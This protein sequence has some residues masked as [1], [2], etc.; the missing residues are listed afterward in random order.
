[1][2][3]AVLAAFQEAGCRPIP[4]PLLE[5]FAPARMYALEWQDLWVEIPGAD[6]LR[7]GTEWLNAIWTSRFR[8]RFENAIGLTTVQPFA[9][10]TPLSPPVPLV[11]LSPK[12]PE[13][14]SHWRFLQALVEDLYRRATRLPFAIT[15]PTRHRVAES[16]RPPTPLFVLHFLVYYGPALQ[17][18][19][20]HILAAPHRELRRRETIVPIHRATEATPHTLLAILH[21]PETWMPTRRIPLARRLGG[22]A[23]THVRHPQTE[24]TTD[25]APNRFVL[26][27]LRQL[28]QA[29]ET[30]LRQPWWP[31]VPQERQKA[32]HTITSLVQQ[33]LQHPVFHHVSDLHFMPSHSQVLLRRPG[34]REMWELW[35][36]FQ[37]ARRPVFEPM[38]QAIEL[39]D[40]ATLYEYWVFFA[41]IEEIGFQLEVTPTVQWQF[42]RDEGLGWHA[43]AQFQNEGTLVYNKHWEGYSGFLRPDFTWERHNKPEV[44]LDAKFR[45]AW[46]SPPTKNESGA[47][48]VVRRDDLDKMH[49]YRDALRVRAAVA[50][51]PGE[52]SEFFD[53][54]HGRRQIT[55]RELLLED[56]NGVGALALRPDVES[57]HRRQT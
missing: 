5:A 37:Q 39:R 51:Y 20:S 7:V 15:A 50:I 34:Y 23:P 9:G 3:S 27:F 21:A 28:H 54:T 11:V 31:N 30:L 56:L 13:P 33:A 44:V 2:V 45:L 55:L 40:I 36:I 43:H 32:V 42:D 57:Y 22:Y 41:L 29:A 6:R 16:H 1:M 4:N 19:L 47:R 26:H 18:A 12:F 35:H 25:T 49:T 53:V 48:R 52:T 17:Q 14:K 46:E 24:E 8:V 38:Y 10:E